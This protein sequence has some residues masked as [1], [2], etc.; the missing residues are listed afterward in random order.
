MFLINL[1]SRESVNDIHEEPPVFVNGEDAAK[2]FYGFPVAFDLVVARHVDRRVGGDAGG[3]LSVQ[4]DELLG[5]V[6]L[7]SV[8]KASLVVHDGDAYIAARHARDF[9]E[10]QFDL[11]LAVEG[12]AD[13]ASLF[14]SGFGWVFRTEGKQVLELIFSGVGVESF[15]SI[16][17]LEYGEHD[18]PAGASGHAVEG[19][20]AVEFAGEGLLR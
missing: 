12:A 3:V 15:K 9:K 16:I 7:A 19:V 1:P 17:V 18:A 8:M 6:H 4:T 14:V 20:V 13:A 11:G 2:A 10:Q 5:G